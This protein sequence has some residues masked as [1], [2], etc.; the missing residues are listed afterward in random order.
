LPRPEAQAA[1]KALCQRARES[2]IP[3]HDLARDAWPE[4]ELDAIFN[5]AAQLGAAPAEA[6]A[7]ARDTAAANGGTTE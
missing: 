2:G 5:P 3:L 7:F 1:V 6:R 4:G